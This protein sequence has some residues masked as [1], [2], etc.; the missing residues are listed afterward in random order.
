MR[1]ID[2]RLDPL[3]CAG[4]PL[5]P[6]HKRCERH[7]V[8]LNV[9]NDSALEFHRVFEPVDAGLP[10]RPPV[11][12]QLRLRDVAAVGWEELLKL[13]LDS[14]DIV[15]ERLRLPHQTVRL[16]DRAG[17]LLQCRELQRQQI[18]RL[19]LQNLDEFAGFA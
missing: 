15:S 12:E 7:L 6:I 9:R 4:R 2:C 3:R 19:V 10:V 18:A 16:V 17:D 8:G 1:A 13:L 11:R 5:A 14:R